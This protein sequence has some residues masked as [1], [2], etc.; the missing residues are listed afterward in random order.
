MAKQKKKTIPVTYYSKQY[1]VD[2]PSKLYSMLKEHLDNGKELEIGIYEV[3]SAHISPGRL[4]NQKAYKERKNKAK[5]IKQDNKNLGNFILLKFNRGGTS[6]KDLTD[7]MLARLVFLATYLNYDGKLMIEPRKPMTKA[8]IQRILGLSRNSFYLFWNKVTQGEN[9]YFTETD[10]GILLAY[11]WCS[12]GKQKWTGY[13][14]GWVKVY[15]RSM[16][17]LYNANPKHH[18]YIG[19]VFRMLPYINI[20]SN[21]LCDNPFEEDIE[22]SQPLN[23][24]EIGR[25]LHISER[26]VRSLNTRYKEIMCDPIGGSTPWMPLCT[27]T[28]WKGSQLILSVNPSVIAL[29]ANSGQIRLK[30]ADVQN[31]GIQKKGEETLDIPEFD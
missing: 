31:L 15:I 9:P 13:E 20:Y 25:R 1:E 10:A 2:V 4:K 14:I 27:T 30:Q 22:K 16:R 7:I 17:E 8:D 23:M 5:A 18:R 24:T 6:F 21:V 29:K 11:K 28:A 12:R 26:T 19:L 3:G